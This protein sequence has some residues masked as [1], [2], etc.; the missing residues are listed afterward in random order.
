VDLIQRCYTGIE[1]R[2]QH[3]W[4]NPTLPEEL[5]GLRFRVC[6]RGQTVELDI[7][8]DLVRVRAISPQTEAIRL[9]VD[10]KAVSSETGKTLEVKLERA[11]L[12]VD[13][14]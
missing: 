8:H 12:F 2:D 14:P 3:L 7:G 4:L 10:S 9:H 13:A 5:T 1:I 11:P 6:F